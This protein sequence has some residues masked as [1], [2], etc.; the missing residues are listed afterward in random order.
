MADGGGKGGLEADDE[1]GSAGVGQVGEG[2]R[3]ESRESFE[4]VM[5]WIVDGSV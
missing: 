1:E 5:R 2:V 3:E 4:E